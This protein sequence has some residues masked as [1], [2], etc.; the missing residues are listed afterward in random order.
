L[1]Q[2]RLGLRKNSKLSSGVEPGL[3]Q[4]AL[5][6]NQYIAAAEVMLKDGH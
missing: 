4:G 6:T 1:T 5:A 2:A 3:F